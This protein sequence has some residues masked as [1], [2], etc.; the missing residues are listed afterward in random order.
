MVDAGQTYYR[1][2]KPQ[3]FIFRSISIPN[4]RDYS[5]QTLDPKFLK[6]RSRL[7][8]LIESSSETPTVPQAVNSLPVPKRV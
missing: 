8:Y 2:R 6:R 5:E 1:W 4:Q 3:E 7:G